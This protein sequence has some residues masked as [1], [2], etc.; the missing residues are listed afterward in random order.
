MNVWYDILIPD[1]GVSTAILDPVDIFRK[2]CKLSFG[3]FRDHVKSRH[4]IAISLKG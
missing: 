3:L 4:L 1:F 2:W